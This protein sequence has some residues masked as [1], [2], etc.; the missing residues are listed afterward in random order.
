[1]WVVKISERAQLQKV[2]ITEGDLA[3]TKLWGK[4]SFNLAG[5]M[6]SVSISDVKWQHVFNENIP[7]IQGCLW[8]LCG[9]SWHQVPGAGNTEGLLC[10][11]LHTPS[12][13]HDSCLSTFYPPSWQHPCEVGV[14]ASYRE[15][16][17]P[18]KTSI[19][20]SGAKWAKGLAQ[21]LFSFCSEAA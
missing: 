3:S 5:E 16:T 4:S 20:C 11:T 10:S 2:F 12:W 19:T 13:Q 7:K 15:R 14:T 21:V 17:E 8:I 6:L 18:G 1:M 9:K